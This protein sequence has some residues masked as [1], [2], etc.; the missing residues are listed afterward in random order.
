MTIDYYDQAHPETGSGNIG[1]AHPSW[2][3]KLT[4]ARTQYN[5]DRPTLHIAYELINEAVA[6]GESWAKCVQCG[7]PYRLTNTWNDETL[8]SSECWA[9]YRISMFDEA[10]G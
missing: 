7:S 9:D 6:R 5:G 3:E 10:A 2:L 8:C 1:K 4:A